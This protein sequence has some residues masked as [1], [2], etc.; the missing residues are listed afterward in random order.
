MASF[1]KFL[2]SCTTGTKTTKPTSISRSV[3][4][5]LLDP[6]HDV[7][8]SIRKSD[9]H[10]ESI[11]NFSTARINGESKIALL[12]II[13]D[14]LIHEAIWR[15]WIEASSPALRDKVCI[16]IHAK[17]PDRVRSPWV[18]RHL[19]RFNIKATW[20]SVELTKVMINLL[21]EV[22]NDD[23]DNAIGRYCFLS[24]SCIPL[25]SLDETLVRIYANDDED[26]N[27]QL[28]PTI[29]PT[30]PIR[31]MSWVNFSFQPMDGFVYSNQFQPLT[32]IIPSDCICRSDQ[33]VM[34]TVDHVQE[35]LRLADFA[36][37]QLAKTQL[38][39]RNSDFANHIII[40]KF[41]NVKASDEMYFPTVLAILGHITVGS[42]PQRGA[43]SGVLRRRVTYCNWEGQNRSPKTF[44][45][46]DLEAVTKARAEGCLF[47][48]KLI[49]GDYDS[50]PDI[51]S[52]VN[53]VAIIRDWITS[54]LGPPLHV[55]TPENT[56]VEFWMQKAFEISRERVDTVSSHTSSDQRIRKRKFS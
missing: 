54:V 6:L 2:L 26:I 1:H 38:I 10:I 4:K 45:T 47:F 37:E 50:A 12:F 51:D 43:S 8:H 22:R 40:D 41:K 49:P 35:I 24:E 28:L 19:V 27:V 21:H 14:D 18:T 3:C 17:F 33:W 32:E 53:L 23:I 55:I 5:P 52:N 7:L 44:S 25:F 9:S 11:P 13:I 15:L 48:R 16:F 20:G 56:N 34:L 30:P 36:S 29:L 42:T 39:K 46:F 31:A